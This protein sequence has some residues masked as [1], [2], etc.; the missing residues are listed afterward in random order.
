MTEIQFKWCT[1]KERIYW[2]KKLERA[3][4]EVTLRALET[5]TTLSGLSFSPLATLDFVSP[6]GCREGGPQLSASIITSQ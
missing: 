5:Q 6:R 2:P 1:K 3:G 4:V